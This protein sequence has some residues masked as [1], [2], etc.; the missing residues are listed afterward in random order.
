MPECCSSGLRPNGTAPA[1]AAR[2]G[3]EPGSNTMSAANTAEMT[4]STATAP[5][6]S[7]SRRLRSTIATMMTAMAS[8]T[9]QNRNE[10][11]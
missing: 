8:T 6:V 10:P 7:L 9:S 1:S 5:P 2:N 3:L 11:C 4:A